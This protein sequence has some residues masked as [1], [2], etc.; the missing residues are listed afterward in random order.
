MKHS[1]T[2]KA[3]LF[4]IVALILILLT[5]TLL[6]GCSAQ[7]S[8]NRQVEKAY[9]ELIDNL[10]EKLEDDVYGF[11]DELSNKKIEYIRFIS[12]SSSDWSEVSDYIRDSDYYNYFIHIFVTGYYAPQKDTVSYDIFYSI[13]EK[14]YN[15]LMQKESSGDA[16][17]YIE[18]LNICFAN[19][20]GCPRSYAAYHIPDFQLEENEYDKFLQ[21][22]KLKNNVEPVGFLPFYLETTTSEE[23]G[24]KKEII[25]YTVK[26]LSFVNSDTENSVLPDHKHLVLSPNSNKNNV[27]AF[28]AEYEISI[29]ADISFVIDNWNTSPSENDVALKAMNYIYD[30]SWRISIQESIRGGSEFPLVKIENTVLNETTTPTLDKLMNGDFNFEKPAE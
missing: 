2:H 21:L 27:K 16:L 7:A 26:G 25:T 6:A 8:Y 11:Y 15:N 24:D 4:A 13:E 12:K 1:Y 17:A 22:F 5:S 3:R 28:Y 29:L 10:Q 9:N 20:T 23:I 19:R 30:N 18:A 14:Y